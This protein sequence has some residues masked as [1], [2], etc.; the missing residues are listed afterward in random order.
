MN[1]AKDVLKKVET[2]HEQHAQYESNLEKA[3]AWIENAKEILWNASE[4]AS[5]SS[6]REEFQSRLDKVSLEKI[7]GKSV[8][9]L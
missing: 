1:L 6:S 5:L 2:N 3:R 7:T 8:H 9:C 4:N